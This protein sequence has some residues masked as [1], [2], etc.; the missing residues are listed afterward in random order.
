MNVQKEFDELAIKFENHPHV[1]LV[2]RYDETITHNIFAGADLFVIPS[3]FEPCGL[4]QMYAMR[5]GAIPVVRKTGGL[6]DSVFDVDNDNILE[7]KRNGFT[8][9]EPTEEALAC[10][11]ERAFKYFK[12]QPHWWAELGK[13]VMCQDLSWDAAPIDQYIKLYEHTVE[14]HPPASLS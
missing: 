4:T 9:T 7:E 11:L 1:R 13:K 2:L 5:Y 8:F 10:A 12:E 14:S 3:I 6:A